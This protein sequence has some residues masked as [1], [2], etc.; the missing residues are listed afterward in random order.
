[1]PRKGEVLD[2]EVRVHEVEAP[3]PERQ[4]LV[5][6]GVQVLVDV[7]VRASRVVVDVHAHE[8]NDAV[9]VVAKAGRPPTPCV[10]HYR[11]GTQGLVEQA[12]LDERVVGLHRATL[13]LYSGMRGYA[14]TFTSRYSVSRC[15]GVFPSALMRCTSSSVVV[16]YVVPAAETTFS[17][18]ITEPM[19]SAP[20]PSAT[21]PTFMPCVTQDD[22]MCGTL[23]R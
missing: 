17:S 14:Y 22:W 18:I 15:T 6:I 10:E 12:S 9:A 20:K 1:V 8:T 21:C 4:R 2:H 5:E 7:Q 13:D 3:V 11:S 19:S 16:R 23:S